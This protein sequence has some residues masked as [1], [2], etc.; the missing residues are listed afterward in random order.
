MQLAGVSYLY[1]ILFAN[2]VKVFH[3]EKGL[4]QILF[5]F[6]FF[7]LLIKYLLQLISALPKIGEA[8]FLNREV[9][10]G[11]IHLV[12]LGVISAGII[13]WLTGNGLL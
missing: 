7:A 2:E 13:G 6:S 12:M 10:I 4:P 3:C 1:K 9:T 11:F 8:A 5:R